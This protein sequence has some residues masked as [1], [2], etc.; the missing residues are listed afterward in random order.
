MSAP[1]IA[2]ATVIAVTSGKGG[3]GKTHVAINVGV[4]LA[5]LGYRT[6]VIDADFALGNVDVLLGLSGEH[7]LG[8]VM[9]G[10]RGLRDVALTGPQG[11]QVFP[12]SS[13]VQ[14]L[15]TLSAGQQGTLADA[16]RDVRGG[17]DFLLVDTAT[18]ISDGVLQAIGLADQVLLVASMEPAGLVD[19]YATIKV[20]NS[21]YPT[22][23][24]GVVVNGVVDAA[25]AQLAFRQ[26]DTA[27]DRFL[28]RSLRY[29]GFVSRDPLVQDAI[30]AQR[31]VVDHN[32]Q[33]PASR[34]FRVLASRIAGLAPGHGRGTHIG[35]RGASG[36]EMPQCA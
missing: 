28:K 34:C 8:H 12:A 31:P 22:R 32:P 27:A 15:A 19:A 30:L 20:L 6:G 35:A 24:I 16:V 5:R 1:G 18:G 29:L 25:E 33:A 11:L 3:V 23:P 36:M 21:R 13:G 10:Q 26:L 9:T 2:T 7:H 14:S 4:A 17:F